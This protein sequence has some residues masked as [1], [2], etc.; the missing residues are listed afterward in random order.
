MTGSWQRRPL[1]LVV[2]GI[3]ISP[4]GTGPLCPSARGDT[5]RQ[6]VVFSGSWEVNSANLLVDY[7]H[8]LLED[9]NFETFRDRVT[10]Q[11]TE[12]MLCR[13]L[14]NSP[15]VTA[16]R[17]AVVSLGFAGGFERSNAALGRALRDSDVTVRKLAEDALWSVWSRADTPE[18]NQVLQEVKQ[19][20]GSG[21]LRRAETLAN[22]LIT[23]A[24]GFAEAYNQRA[25]IYFLLGRFAESARD[26]Q[27]VLSRN[28]YHFGALGGL[29]QCQMQLNKPSEA[30]KTLRY[31]L[32][33]QPYSDGLRENIRLVEAQI[34]PPGSH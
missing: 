9:R 20:I 27:H 19:L 14:V 25:I 21:Q 31:A 34:E 4:W 16:R 8:K 1:F 12:E 10:T 7:F 30:L 2:C 28:P 18:N 29:A 3:A 15:A 32:K 5:N 17:A 13:I 23:A 26:C 24:P 33:L 11:Y 6:Q 22:R